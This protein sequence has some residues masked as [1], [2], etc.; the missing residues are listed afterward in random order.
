MVQVP[1]IGMF[2]LGL[3]CLVALDQML[4]LSASGSQ[5]TRPAQE[6][7]DPAMPDGLSSRKI[8]ARRKYMPSTLLFFK[9]CP[10]EGLPLSPNLYRE[11]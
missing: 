7:H 1:L 11:S 8:Q 2:L 4:C 10:P 6:T 3:L 5:G 9:D